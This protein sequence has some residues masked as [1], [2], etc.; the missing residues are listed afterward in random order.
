[1]H[2]AIRFAVWIEETMWKF[3]LVWITLSSALNE[4]PEMTFSACLHFAQPRLR[5]LILLQPNS[6]PPV[7]GTMDHVNL[8]L[9]LKC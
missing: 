6:L 8:G 2:L 9:C 1:M 7:K 3:F 5:D 4:I